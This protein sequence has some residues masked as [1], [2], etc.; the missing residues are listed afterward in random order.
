MNKLTYVYVTFV[1]AVTHFLP[2][3]VYF[4]ISDRTVDD[5]LF[6]IA[7]SSVG[8]FLLVAIINMIIVI[9]ID[10]YLL[11]RYSRLLSLTE[12]QAMIFCDRAELK[13]SGFANYYSYI[14]EP[15]ILCFGFVTVE[16]LTVI[17]IRVCDVL[18]PIV[19]HWL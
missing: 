13:K 10:I 5:L 9:L 11:I 6:T 12:T 7:I 17:T 1:F 19:F 2:F 14:R 18:G 4:L 16:L 15:A 8:A 3:K